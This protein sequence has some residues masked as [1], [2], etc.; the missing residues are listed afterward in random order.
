MFVFIMFCCSSEIVFDVA[1]LCAQL[2]CSEMFI[3]CSNLSNYFSARDINFKSSR[4]ESKPDI[5]CRQLINLRIK[6]F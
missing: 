2:P 4:D 5:R 3:L 6:K 1:V